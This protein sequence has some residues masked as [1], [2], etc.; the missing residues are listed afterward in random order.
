VPL[1]AALSEDQRKVANDL[2]AGPMGFMPGGMKQGGM[3]QGGMMP[4]QK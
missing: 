2:L 4:M 1:Y 3:A